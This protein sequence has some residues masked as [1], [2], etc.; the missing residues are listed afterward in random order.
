VPLDLASPGCTELKRSAPAACQQGE[1][2]GLK[3]VQPMQP[4]SATG[5]LITGAE[6]EAL[7]EGH[8]SITLGEAVRLTGLGK[9]TLARAIKAGR[10][11]G[12]TEN[13]FRQR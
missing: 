12:H 8:I 10:P 9:T 7:H 1:E 11:S 2:Q 4:V 3:V 13:P 5:F 6:Q